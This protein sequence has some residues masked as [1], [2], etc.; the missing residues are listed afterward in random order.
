MAVKVNIPEDIRLED[1]EARAHLAPAVRELRAE[2]RPVARRLQ[3]RTVWMVNSTAQGGGVAEMLPTIVAL[4]R[5]L[6]IRT[7]WAVVETEEEDFFHLTKNL[8]NAIHGVGRPS[9][10]PAERT[11]FEGVSRRNAEELRAWLKPGDLLIAHDPQPM[12]VARIL[13]EDL[14]LSTVWRCHIGLDDHNAATQAA[15]EFLAPY[16]GAYDHAIFSA[17]E[18]IPEYLTACSSVIYP[19]VNPLT[20]KNRDLSVHKIAGILTASA[21]ATNPGPVLPD[22][23]HWVAQRLQANGSFAPANMTD[24]IGFLTRPLVTQVSRWDHL[25]GFRPLLR[26][27]AQLKAGARN[28]GNDTDRIHRRRLDLVRLV[29]V[30]PDPSSVTDDPEGQEVL[31]DLKG[32]YAGLEPEV[33]RDVALLT[34]PM[35][36]RRDNALMVNAIQR[37][38]SVV[39]QNSLREGFGLTITEA[40]WKGIPV[41][42]NYQA[43]GP[44]QQLRD[45]LDGRMI[46]D[47]TDEA[48]LAR[49]LDG[50]L[51]A[52]DK[53]DAWGRSGQ[54]R[55]Y[56]E[57]LIF[58]QLRRWFRVLQD[59]LAV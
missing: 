45:D 31:E 17:P 50:M 10:G 7:E 52:P 33:Q 11:V 57:F 37:T 28:N 14:D 38:S 4:M 3:G 16:A 20:H 12:A 5:D 32:E 58:T 49:A 1:Y 26:A 19:A 36:S 41:L 6:G 43:C 54:R 2:A 44:R 29:L 35:E 34:L 18:Y 30:G 59:K 24:D 13:Q 15:W 51:R 8:H 40:M 56:S 9:F 46:T 55:V 23:F 39:V 21:L 47:P 42:S 22:P 27:F 48:A 53:R 25:K